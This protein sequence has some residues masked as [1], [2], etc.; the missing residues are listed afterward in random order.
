MSLNYTL[1]ALREMN[2]DTVET[3][4]DCGEMVEFCICEYLPHEGDDYAADICGGDE[5][6]AP[7]WEEDPEPHLEGEIPGRCWDA[8]LEDKERGLI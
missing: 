8:Y 7:H 2:N 6:V 1:A 4:H 5:L 3:C